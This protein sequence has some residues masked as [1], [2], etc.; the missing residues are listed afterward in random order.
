MSTPK[1]Q[2]KRAMQQHLVPCLRALGFAGGLTGFRR[3]GA[4]GIDVLVVHTFKGV[5]QLDAGRVKRRASLGARTVRQDW[6]VYAGASSAQG[7][8]RRRLETPAGKGVWRYDN[9][10]AP[11]DFD[12]IAKAMTRVVQRAG[13][14]FWAEEAKAPQRTRA[15]TPT[16]NRTRAMKALL[17]EL[18]VPRLR[19]LG[20]AGSFSNSGGTFRRVGPMVE[21]ASVSLGGENLLVQVAARTSG[22]RPGAKTPGTDFLMA[23]DREDVFDESYAEAS[24]AALRALV[25]AAI[26]A[27][28]GP[29]VR[30]WTRWAPK[31]A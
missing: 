19:T 21:L 1:Q 24:P 12:R 16:V 7:A 18:L 26:R 22:R 25:R 10:R 29:G 30:H 27:I 28:E 17:L 11:A 2:L 6:A 3:L 4:L 31:R 23:A 5:A 13:V 9:L 8:S 20:F 14:A 15:A